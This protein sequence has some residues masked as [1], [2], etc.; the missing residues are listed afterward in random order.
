[1]L[2]FGR[3]KAMAGA[4]GSM[5]MDAMQYRKEREGVDEL[6]AADTALLTGMADYYLENL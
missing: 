4:M 2:T 5:Y 1:M 6:K 3:D